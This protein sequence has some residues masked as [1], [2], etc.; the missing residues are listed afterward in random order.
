MRSDAQPRNETRRGVV[1]SLEH[2][3]NR[4][5]AER[6]TG[7]AAKS[8]KKENAK[9]TL[10]ELITAVGDF[11]DAYAIYISAGLVFGLGGFVINK[12]IKAGR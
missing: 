4:S 7:G 9:M 3:S 6:D 2:N 8:K 10:A 5:A 12:L 11:T 1:H